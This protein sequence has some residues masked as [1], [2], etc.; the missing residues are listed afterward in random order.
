MVFKPI[1]L[2][3]GASGSAPMNAALLSAALAALP[4]LFDATLSHDID[5]FES[6]ALRSLGR[7]IGF[8]GAVW[9]SGVIG[10]SPGARFSIT[11]ASVLDR[12]ATLLGEYA[13][14]S[15][16]DPVT[17]QFLSGP[18]R[19]I[20][21]SAEDYY[22]VGP[23]AA[24]GEYLHRHHVDHLLL[25][26]TAEADGANARGQTSGDAGVRRWLTAYRE[27]AEPFDGREVAGLQALLPL[28]N[29]ARALC[30]ARHM[31]RLARDHALAGAAVALCDRSG[32]IHAAEAGFS[33]M[34]G[35]R[36]GNIVT[37]FEREAGALPAFHGAA[38]HGLCLR[39]EQASPWLLVQATRC[40]PG[41]MLSPR[42]RQVAR[43]FVDGLSH[44][45]IAR[46]IGSSPST[47]RT[48]LQS[49]YAKLGVHTRTELQRALAATPA[50]KTSSDQTPHA[51]TR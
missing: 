13:E 32:L 19:P 11:H 24:V 46:E 28:W 18:H 47:V 14:V 6:F 37:G 45:E 51:G 27:S 25:V 35:L 20:A 49:V 22:R 4:P 26:G 23:S 29:Q 3:A 40:G 31:D 38:A 10:D 48:Q 16:L 9:G 39:A 5:A 8:D 34:T 41:A 44:K 12:P 36:R 43:S 21:A 42:E 17:R 15:A 7:L 30:L 33:E 2:D 50:S 1:R